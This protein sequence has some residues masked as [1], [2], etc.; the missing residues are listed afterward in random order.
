MNRARKGFTM[1]QTRETMG[2]GWRLA[3]ALVLCALGSTARAEQTLT[4]ADLVGRMTD[5]SHV[6]VLP[7][8]GEKCAQWS[9]YDRASQYDEKTGK[10]VG[11]DAN[12]DGSG[13]IRQ[14]GKQI[15]MA[16]MEGPGCIWRI[17]AAAGFKG[18]VRIYLDGS[19]TPVV[20]MPFQ[21]YFSGDTVPFNY[22]MLSYNLGQKIPVGKMDVF[23]GQN[24]Y[25]PIPYQKSCK[26]VAD[27]NWGLFYHFTYS[28]FPKGTKVPT[29]SAALAAENAAALQKVNDFFR[30]KIGEDPAGERPGQETLKKTVALAPGATVP[31]ADLAGPRAI[32]ALRVK[33]SFSDRQDQMAG[34]R[35]TALQITWD[36]QAQPAVWSPL[37]DFF[38]TAPGENLFKSLTCGMTE[39][40]C[41]S[42]WYMP[43]ASK[44]EVAL[45]NE[46]DKPRNIEI[47]IVHAPLERP[48][49]GLG[50]FHAKWHRG[51]GAMPKDRF[52]DWVMLQ[53]QGRGRFCGAMLHVWN[54]MGGW[55]GEGDEK[56]FVDGEKF[57]STFGTGSEDYFGYAWCSPALFQRPYHCQTMTENNRG[58]QSVA[59]WHIGDNIPFRTS[60]EGC[61]EKY[62]HP[63]PGVQYACS[64]RWYLAPDGTDPYD[65][66]P[67]TKRD[68]YYIV[69]PLVVNGIEVLAKTA[70]CVASQKMT[71]YGAGKWLNDAQLWWT[72]AAPKAKLDLRVSVKAAGKHRI[73]LGVTKAPDYAIV[74]FYLD[75]NKVGAPV[76]LFNNGVIPA[77]VSLGD[78]ELTAGD[79]KLTVEIVG[80][81][82]KAQQRYM[83]GLH[84]VDMTPAN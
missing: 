37:G 59:R 39:E 75:G 12:G 65:A 1:K 51:T 66:V 73:N 82:D 10:Y 68:G 76:D 21:N 4:Y 61:I 42:Y 64:A 71:S 43:F 48:F 13:V 20:D 22:P 35:K 74:Q 25:L 45:V 53:T 77:V 54:P 30:D 52:P 19:E 14:E 55:W 36:G 81:N 72:G 15:V 8:D 40:G 67:A 29:F 33:T 78:H 24:L 58:H 70:G 6:A 7:V 5:L 26:V 80:A 28:T 23:N 56:F 62:D 57:P 17:W 83:F 69:I 31:V 79:H 41:Y 27:E 60:F 50:H 47:E 38:G 34:L 16:E 44:A 32:T 46:G 63:G 49:E 84:R 3:L 11:W 2:R 18:H 9:S